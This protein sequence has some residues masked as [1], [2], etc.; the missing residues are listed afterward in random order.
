MLVLALAACTKDGPSTRPDDAPSDSGDSVT[1]QDTDAPLNE[2]D[3]KARWVEIRD[4]VAR[5]A[6]C[7]DGSAPGYYIRPGIGDGVD[8]WIVWLEG[9]GGCWTTEGC[10]ERWESSRYRMSSHNIAEQLSWSGGVVDPDA[11]TNASFANWNHVRLNYCSSDYWIGDRVEPRPACTTGGDCPTKADHTGATPTE[12]YYRGSR[13]LRAAL[14]DLSQPEISKIPS[15]TGA[16]EVIY[17][18]CSAG[19]L[20]AQRTIDSTTAYL[21][22]SNPDVR[23]VGL[24]DA[25]WRPTDMDNLDQ[26]S[27]NTREM[28]NFW[29]D[30]DGEVYIDESCQAAA[31]NQGVESALCIRSAILKEHLDTPFF[32]FMDQVDGYWLDDMCPPTRKKAKR[33]LAYIKTLIAKGDPPAEILKLMK[34]LD[35][36][37]TVDAVE[38]YLYG[39][40]TDTAT[41]V[42]DEMVALTQADSSRGA[43]S[44]QWYQHCTMGEDEAFFKVPLND[45]TPQTLA[46][47]INIWYFGLDGEATLIDDQPYVWE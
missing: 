41:S 12:F 18:G 46:E 43:F 36:E 31:A 5:G 29:A 1:P 42:R 25:E 2:P 39:Y 21:A 22:A 15:I 10:L 16:S 26:I 33:V 35:G 28:V 45:S 20:G 24:F 9:G 13:I 14:E 23:V 19:S 7:N 17:G 8:K 38:S 27:T 40:C 44:P 32:V 47:T 34:G 3:R 4:H 30:D 6:I 11:D 37:L